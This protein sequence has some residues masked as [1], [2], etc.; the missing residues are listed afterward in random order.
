MLS[1]QQW[2][3]LRQFTQQVLDSDHTGHGMDH[4]DRVVAIAE[5]LAQQTPTAKRD[6]VVVAALLHDT[7]DQKLVV[8]VAAAKANT[9]QAMQTATIAQDDQQAIFAIID[10]MSYRY[11]LDHPTPLSLEGQLVQD[12]DRLDAIGAIGIAR[13]FYYGG[14][15]DTPMYQP[16][17]APRSELDGQTYRQEESSVINHFY[18]K[19]LLLQDLLNTDAAKKIAQHRQQVMLDFLDE[20]KAEWR[21]ER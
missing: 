11:Q 2:A 4:I 1:T 10:Q 7:Y 3:Q 12:A 8:D 17:V 18:E 20:F 16:D 19:L 9:A 5:Q 13:T 14:T 21:G 6:I 15:H